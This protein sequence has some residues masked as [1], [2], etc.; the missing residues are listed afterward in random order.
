[1]RELG[2][3]EEGETAVH[4]YTMQEYADKQGISRQAAYSRLEKWT[5]LGL[6]RRVREMITIPVGEEV[7][8][9]N[10]RILTAWP[11]IVENLIRIATKGKE[12]NAVNAFNSLREI[13]KELM[14]AQPED[15]SEESAYIKG[16]LVESLDPMSIVE[17][18]N[19]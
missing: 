18:G 7:V 14:D 8:I 3:V 9:A 11:E 16:R 12:H 6:L 17:E 1:M 15:G 10:R 19:S 13:Q 5:T 4:R 2:V